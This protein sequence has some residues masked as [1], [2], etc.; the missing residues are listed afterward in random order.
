[1]GGHRIVVDFQGD[2][3][4]LK[5]EHLRAATGLDA[6]PELTPDFDHLPDGRKGPPVGRIIMELKTDTPKTTENFRALCTGA[7]APHKGFGYAG[8]FFHRFEDENFIH[9]H[10]DPGTLSMANAGPNTNGSQFFLCTVATPWL[11]G[12][13]TVFGQ[14]IDG[15][16]IVKTIETVGSQ[17]GK[18]SKPV[19]ITASG[20]LN[21]QGQK[22]QIE[23][24]PGGNDEDHVAKE[25]KEGEEMSDDGAP[26]AKRAKGDDEQEVPIDL[27]D[28]PDDDKQEQEVK[29]E[30]PKPKKKTIDAEAKAYAEAMYAMEADDDV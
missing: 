14:V 27:A 28:A 25:T 2:Y 9:K 13:H 15:M 21:P 5:V 17:T 22:L 16:D 20:E 26:S 18:T 10:V 11:D 8:S 4:A 1:M 29:E 24:G 6:I 19:K 12:K 23:G 7:A 30:A 3:K